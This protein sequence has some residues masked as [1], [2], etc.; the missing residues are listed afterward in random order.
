MQKLRRIGKFVQKWKELKHFFGANQ[1]D[2]IRSWLCLQVK[3]LRKERTTHNSSTCLNNKLEEFGLC[4]NWIPPKYG[5]QLSRKTFSKGLT[6]F[7][8]EISYMISCHLNQMLLSHQ[9]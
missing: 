4:T 6:G 2:E 9:M 7:Y 1:T 5:S 3:M 8:K